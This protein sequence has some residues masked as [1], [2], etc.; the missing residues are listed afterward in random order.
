MARFVEWL[1]AR[2]VNSA[3]PPA[4]ETAAGEAKLAA[5]SCSVEALQTQPQPPTAPGLTAVDPTFPAGIAQ[6]EGPTLTATVDAAVHRVLE[7]LH[8]ELQAHAQSFTHV[9]EWSLQPRLLC[10]HDNYHKQGYTV[11]DKLND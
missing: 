8:I 1:Y 11:W 5:A 10:W 4:G 7:Q 3:I 2:T 9:E 6:A